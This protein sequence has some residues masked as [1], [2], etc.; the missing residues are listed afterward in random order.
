MT[1][2]RRM[3][4][5]LGVAIATAALTWMVGWWAVAA[6]GLVAGMLPSR[7][8]IGAA[9]TSLGGA[10]GWA[11][12]MLVHA[13]HPTFGGLLS[14]IAGVFQLP[15]VIFVLVT[16]LYAALLAWSASVIG[17]TMMRARSGREASHVT[18]AAPE[19]SPRYEAAPR[20][21][22]EPHVR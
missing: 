5:V 19:P 15:G 13:T 17:S 11:L 4:I 21:T 12:L 1:P 20:A 16:L 18:N 10:L 3:V 9:W 6:V 14:R 7:F 22:A 2:V 8:R